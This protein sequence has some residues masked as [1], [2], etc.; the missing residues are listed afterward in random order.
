MPFCVF[1]KLKNEIQITDY[2]LHVKID[3]Y[4]EILMLSFVSH[5]P[6]KLKT[7]YSLFFV[8]PFN[9]GIDEKWIK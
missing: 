5:S 3:F 8:F 7:K 4:F 1:D 2:Y 6:E 9:E